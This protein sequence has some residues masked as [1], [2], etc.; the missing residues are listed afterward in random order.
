M[1]CSAA[2]E[3]AIRAATH[4]ARR[5]SGE[6]VRTRDISEA[7][8]IP[9][10]FLSSVLRRLVAAGLLESIRGPGGGYQ[11]ARPADRI[12]LLDIV[13][14][15]DGAAG[16]NACA[17]GLTKCSDDVPCP[18]HESWKPIRDQIHDCLKSTTLDRMAEPIRSMS[19]E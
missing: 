16:I 8:Q 15:V 3:Y 10:P 6:F 19:V 14:A 17:V 7:E 18:L 12:A 13:V 2:C 9:A 11:L 1:I 4:L 5:P